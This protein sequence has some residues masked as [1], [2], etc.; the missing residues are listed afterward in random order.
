MQ[1]RELKLTELD[2]AYEVLKELRV[3]LSYDEFED[4]VYQMQDQNYKIF[5]VYERDE[6]ITYAG[7][8]VQSNLYHKRHL[9]MYE[10]VTK[11][12]HRSRGY[13]KEMLFY[14]H[15]Y[16]KMFKC[17]NIVLTSGNQRVDAH[18]FY[19]R[20]GFDKKSFMYVKA[21]MENR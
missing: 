13:A 14:L 3:E 19:E 10:L 6:L 16:A 7:V 15:D 18:R 5:G 21:I 12:T 11:A 1:V 8:S 9:F 2:V 20:E 4:I 17:E